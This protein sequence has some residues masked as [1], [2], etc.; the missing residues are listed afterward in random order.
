M[1]GYVN[2]PRQP[3]RSDPSTSVRMALIKKNPIRMSLT[4]RFKMIHRTLWVSLPYTFSFTTREQFNT[5]QEV[6]SQ[7]LDGR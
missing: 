2:H 5:A 7:Q 6:C 3:S 1:G 4:L